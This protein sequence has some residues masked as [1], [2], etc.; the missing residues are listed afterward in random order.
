M[1]AGTVVSTYQDLGDSGSYLDSLATQLA[2]IK[3]TTTTKEEYIP[4]FNRYIG[5]LQNAQPEATLDD[6]VDEL[7]DIKN[8]LS[9]VEDSIARASYR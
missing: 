5:E 7:Q 8:A 6:V 2:L 1:Y 3:E 9:E 4:M